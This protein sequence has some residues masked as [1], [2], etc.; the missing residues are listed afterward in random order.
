M[1]RSFLPASLERFQEHC[2]RFSGPKATRNAVLA[3]VATML[4]LPAP[5]TAGDVLDRIR[6]NK[7]I[8]VATDPADP[9][10]SFVDVEGA[11]GGFNVDIAR[12]LAKRIGVGVTF[13][14][15]GWRDI[16]SGDWAGRWDVVVG[17]VSPV[18]PRGEELAFPATYTYLPAVLVARADDDR[19]TNP[20]DVDT[21]DA[22]V[23][24]AE[25]TTFDAY[26]SGT[27]EIQAQGGLAAKAFAGATIRR[28]ETDNA[29]LSAL[30]QG[31]SGLDIA[32]TSLP[33]ARQALSDGADIKLIGQPLFLD[34]VG[35]AIESGDDELFYL[36]K[37]AVSEMRSDGALEEAASRWFTASSN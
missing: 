32:L 28:Y 11:Y 5:A 31:G 36:I 37:G 16:A 13:V 2:A 30:V 10:L 25:A 17:G 33:V 3:A 20:A 29:V 1:I 22:T 26:L 34:P 9:P 21:L 7:T 27:L 19:I 12:E 14:T 18:S 23:G 6:T 4:T 8:V 24:V 35:V 15:P